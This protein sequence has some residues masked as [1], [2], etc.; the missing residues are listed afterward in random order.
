MPSF[1]FLVLGMQRQWLTLAVMLAWGGLEEVTCS[2]P[3]SRRTCGSVGNYKPVLYLLWT[4]CKLDFLLLER[5]N[6][7]VWKPKSSLLSAEHNLI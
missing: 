2:G 5:I 6:P 3:S 1:S 4:F 7:C